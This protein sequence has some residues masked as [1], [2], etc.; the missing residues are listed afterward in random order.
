MDSILK[1]PRSL[2]CKACR[3]CGAAPIIFLNDQALYVIKCP[4]SE[5]HYQT[6]PGV[7]DVEDW[8]FHNT[9]LT[10]AGTI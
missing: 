6:S 3:V 4:N 8:N 7:I 1:V 10:E 9:N 2:N 5:S